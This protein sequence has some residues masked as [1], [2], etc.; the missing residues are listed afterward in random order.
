M[1]FNVDGQE[2]DSIELKA[3]LVS[4]GVRVSAEVYKKFGRVAR[5]SKNP[6]TCNSMVLPDNTIVQLTDL[7][8]HMDYIH[9]AMTWDSLAQL[10]YL[11]QLQTNFSLKLDE[12]GEP[13]VYYKKQEITPVLFIA[14]SDFYEQKTSSGLPYL[15]NAVLQGTQWLSFPLLWKCDYALRGEPCQYCFSGGELASL[16]KRHKSLPKYPTPEDV[17]EIVEYAI[18][19]EGCA[20]S[21]QI[22]GGSSF[23][24]RAEIDAIT[25]ILRAIDRRVGLNYIEGE[26]LIYTTPPKQPE[27]ID[28]LFKAGAD[29]VA[30][31]LEI[32]DEELAQKIMPGKMKYTGRNRH[33][34]CLYYIASKYG[35]NKACCNFII[36][37]EPLESVLAGAETMASHG[38][39][40]IASIWVPFGRPVLGSMKAPDLQYYRAF[41]EEMA[42]IDERYGIIPPGGQGLNVCFCRDIYL[43]KCC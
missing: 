10:K 19:K 26:I 37:L 43:K 2:V 9:S 27:A 3:L 20:D 36:G 23:N 25:S 13:A 31:S 38:I 22:T 15:G 40:P 39:V 11:S 34:D 42:R 21:I 17:A 18:F 1:N 14:H 16:A 7:S 5:L 24:D 29:R 32:W 12:A 8:F 41:K 4:R 35:Q 33:L 28:D 30:C 6:L